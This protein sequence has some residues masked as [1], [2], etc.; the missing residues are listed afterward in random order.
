MTCILP[1]DSLEVAESP[2][3]EPFKKKLDVALSDVIEQFGSDEL[4]DGPDNHLSN[5]NNFMILLCWNDFF[6]EV[7]KSSSGCCQEFPFIS[8]V[9]FHAELVSSACF[10]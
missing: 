7:T 5:L 4:M 8:G 1:Q 3:L 9:P 10:L 6:I 2:G